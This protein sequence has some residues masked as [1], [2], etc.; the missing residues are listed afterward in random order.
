MRNFSLIILFAET[1]SLASAIIVMTVFS[2][3]VQASEGSTFGIVPYVRPAVTG[4]IAG[5]VGATGSAGKA[6]HYTKNDD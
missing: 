6:F 2:I 3:F 1:N 4:S 5:I